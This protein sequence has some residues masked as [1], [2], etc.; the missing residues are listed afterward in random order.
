MSKIKG[1]GGA[2]SVHHGQHYMHKG[3]SKKVT[4]VAFSCDE[5][6]W[7]VALDGGPMNIPAHELEQLPLEEAEELEE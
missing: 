4:S 6:C 5:D 7:L 2:F 1:K 3:V